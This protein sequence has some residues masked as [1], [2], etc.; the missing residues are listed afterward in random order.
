[1]MSIPAVPGLFF[2]GLRGATLISVNDDDP[3][4]RDHCIKVNNLNCKIVRAKDLKA[5][6]QRFCRTFG[7]ERVDFRVL[8]VHPSA[9]ASKAR[10][11]NCFTAHRI[12]GDS[13]RL[14]DW[15]AGIAPELA[16]RRAQ[17]FCDDLFI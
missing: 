3:A 7:A 9:Y 1:M 6:L 8:S 2:V 13:G 12:R 5:G 16:F 10:L 15:L 14:H 11:L 17:E 4:R